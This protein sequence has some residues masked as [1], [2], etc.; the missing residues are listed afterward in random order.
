MTE[1]ELAKLK[2]RAGTP[3]IQL[4]VEIA[5]LDKWEICKCGCGAPNPDVNAV[6]HADFRSLPLATAAC[7]LAA[8]YARINQ[9][10]GDLLSRLPAEARAGFVAIL[11]EQAREYS[12][13]EAAAIPREQIGQAEACFFPPAR[14]PGVG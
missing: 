9:L 8:A 13:V 7:C 14:A 12:Q 5:P 10:L 3:A 6:S 2:S 1:E 4:R 11:Q